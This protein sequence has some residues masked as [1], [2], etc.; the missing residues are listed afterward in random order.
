MR[1]DFELDSNSWDLVI[2]DDIGI[3]ENSAMTS[4]DSKFSLQ[5]IQ[6]E[7]FDDNRIGTP[8][9]TDMVSPQ[10]SIAAKKQ[11]IR[12][13]I[14]STPGAI[15]LTRVEVAVDTDSAIATCEFEGITDNG[16]IF[17][18]QVSEI[19]HPATDSTSGIIA[20]FDYTTRRS[21]G[22]RLQRS[23]T[24]TY[25]DEDALK[26]ADVNIPR[27]ENDGLLLEGQ[28][29][30]LTYPSEGWSASALASGEN[31]WTHSEPDQSGWITVTGGTNTESEEGSYKDF[32][33]GATVRNKTAT[34]SIDVKK[35]AGYNFAIRAFVGGAGSD[36]LG[37]TSI[38]F[39]DGETLPTGSIWKIQDNGTWLRISLT[40]KFGDGLSVFRIYPFGAQ[41]DASGALTYRRVQVEEMA[42]ATSYIKTTGSPVTRQPDQLSLIKSGAKFLYREYIPLGSSVITKE[43]IEYAGEIV[44]LNT[45]LQKLKVWDRDLT[46]NEI[47][48]LGV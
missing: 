12:D 46:D 25:I 10:V 15:E 14:M 40:R 47:E 19:N 33:S 8:W 9:L 48:L 17:G 11:I 29:T 27:Y 38:Y 36:G 23:S 26:T 5:L 6:G 39:A 34:L 44:P 18:N 2:T 3:V 37:T 28:S 30:N 32:V 4:Q 41:K 35:V 24:A 1:S 31:R 45:H 7:V 16:D 43:L 21:T 42:L 13:V 22:L 20:T